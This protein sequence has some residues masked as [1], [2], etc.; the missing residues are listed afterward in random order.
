M[1][2]GRI[3]NRKD[4]VRNRVTEGESKGRDNWVM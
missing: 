1:E 4:E 2:V 3:G